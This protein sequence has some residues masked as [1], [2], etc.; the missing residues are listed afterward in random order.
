MSDNK[1]APDE[2]RLELEREAMNMRRILQTPD[3]QKL[4]ETL[5]TE[6]SDRSSFVAGDPYATAYKEGQRSVVLFLKD[7]MEVNYES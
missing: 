2:L 7:L 3:G 6:F 4:Y 1:L 5:D